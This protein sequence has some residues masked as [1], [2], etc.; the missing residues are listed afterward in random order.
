MATTTAPTGFG[1]AIWN[2]IKGGNQVHGVGLT[3]VSVSFAP[4]ATGS[5][6]IPI[7]IAPPQADGGYWKVEKAYIT[8]EGTKVVG[9]AT[10]RWSFEL[11]AMQDTNGDDTVDRNQDITNTAT[12]LT[13][14]AAPDGTDY[15]EFDPIT[16]DVEGPES[17]TPQSV[18]LEAG[19]VLVFEATDPGT[20]QNMSGNTMCV[21]VL[22]RHSP[23]GR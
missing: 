12:A 5:Y 17:A 4:P 2:A 7:F 13:A 18:F 23:P 15:M 21:T 20:V 6:N 9:H 1:R 14:A 22:L 10:N 16:M 11:A 19:D 3:P 8:F